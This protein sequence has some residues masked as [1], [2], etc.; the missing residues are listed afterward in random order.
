MREGGVTR[1]TGGIKGQ[2]MKL[3]VLGC[4]DAFGSGGRFNT[5]FLLEAQGRRVLVDCG[6]SAMIAMNRFGVDPGTIDG[7]VLSHLHGDHFGGLP[8]FLIHQHFKARRD[9]P[10]EILGPPETQDRVTE[11]TAALFCDLAGE[12]RYPLDFRTLTADGAQTLAGFTVEAMRVEHRCGP[13]FGLRLTDGDTTF[14]YSGDTVWTDALPDL[15]AGADLFVM[16]CYAYDE[17]PPTHTDYCTVTAHLPELTARRI[18][19]THLSPSML[20]RRDELTLEVLED[21]QTIEF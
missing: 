5:C 2:A 15:A 21:G 14:A 12:W 6:A 13:A 19:L 20:S 16:E 3:T 4:G 8:F 17:A 10:L 11:A 9:R 1:V 7:V 18:V